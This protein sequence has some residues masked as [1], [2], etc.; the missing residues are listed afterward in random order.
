MSYEC[1]K[2]SLLFD[3]ILAVVDNRI[4]VDGMRALCEMLK[5]NNS[6]TTIDLYCKWFGTGRGNR[7]YDIGCCR[8]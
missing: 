2:G 8:L 5:H 6:V 4:G 7:R 3:L 1:D